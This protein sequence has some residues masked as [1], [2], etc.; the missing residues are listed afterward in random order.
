MRTIVFG[1]GGQLGIEL[2]RECLN[3]G[4]SVTALTRS[5][6]DIAQV[7][8]VRRAIGRHRPHWV[9]NA[10]AYND[11]D[12]AETRYEEA[13]AINA[14]AVSDLA[15][16]CEDHGAGLVHY[17]TDFVFSGKKGSP[18]VEEDVAEPLS[19]YGAVKIVGDVLAQDR[20]AAHYVLRVGGVY[21]PAG[22]YTRRGNFAEFV[23]N[24]CAEG[25]E[26][27]IVGDQFATPT[28]APALAARTLDVL[29]QQIPYGLYHL[30]GGEVLSWY[31]FA[32]KIADA[33][34][35]SAKIV[36]IPYADYAPKVPRPQY[37]AL[38]NGR[39]EALGIAPMPGIDA[40]IRQY[41]KLRPSRDS[42][43]SSSSRGH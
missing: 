39:I 2:A 26:L 30:G 7:D 1:A 43:E 35:C 34:G 24:G 19:I 18:Y 14:A 20:C 4:H 5:D 3:R 38:S 21:G 15:A 23:L 6:A 28:F 40:S 8:V 36:R 31:E 27:R 29:E 37:S 13:L 11:V 32:T 22:R 10:A 17:S 9:L 42:R 25:R 33:A 16:A 12:R 41:L